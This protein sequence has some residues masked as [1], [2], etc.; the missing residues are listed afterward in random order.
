MVFR[1]KVL[2]D[3][4]QNLDRTTGYLLHILLFYFTILRVEWV[5][6]RGEAKKQQNTLQGGKCCTQH[7]QPL[8]HYLKCFFQHLTVKFSAQT[9]PFKFERKVLKKALKIMGKWLKVLIMNALK[10]SSRC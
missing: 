3:S 10:V 7:L 8:S 2:T 1:L 5:R 6:A 4:V 9:L